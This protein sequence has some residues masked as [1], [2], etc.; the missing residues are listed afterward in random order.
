MTDLNLAIKA[1]G[2]SNIA[3]ACG[4]S[5]RAVYKWL[6]KGSLP[7]TEFYGKTHYAATIEQLTAGRFVAEALLEESRQK[8]L[9]G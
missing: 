1:A 5:Q 6:K 8:L 4:I 2:V 9:S 3:S 7:K